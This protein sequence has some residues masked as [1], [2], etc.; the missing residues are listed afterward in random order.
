HRKVDGREIPERC[1]GMSAGLEV[2][3]FGHG[4]RCVSVAGSEC[5]LPDVDQPIFIT[6]DKWAK[7]NAP[8]EAKDG[9]VGTDAESEG[10]DDCKS[11]PLGPQQRAESKSQISSE[12][13]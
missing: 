5:A 10:N 11:E 7:Q 13:S 2:L 6:V 9:G 12:Q 4:E 1:K 3:D 8:H